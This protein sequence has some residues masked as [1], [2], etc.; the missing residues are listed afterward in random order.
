M[1]SEPDH[2]PVHGRGSTID[3]AIQDAWSK[4]QKSDGAETRLEILRIAVHG[5]N[6]I[7]AY[8]VILH[9]TR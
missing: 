1:A 6:P 7:S 4:A 2:V 5:S 8:T 3:E 9:P